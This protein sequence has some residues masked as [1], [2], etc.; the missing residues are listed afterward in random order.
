MYKT[1]RRFA[2]ANLKDGLLSPIE[3][4]INVFSVLIALGDDHGRGLNEGTQHSFFPHHLGMVQDVR[5]SRHHLDQFNEIGSAAS[6]FKAPPLAQPL[7]HRQDI[8]RY[9]VLE[10]VNH[11]LEDPAMSIL[12][13]VT[14]LQNFQNPYERVIVL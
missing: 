14:L 2:L 3:Q 10:Q 4:C 7:G 9:I 8:D 11:S 1:S 13:K 5:C 12:I 6:R